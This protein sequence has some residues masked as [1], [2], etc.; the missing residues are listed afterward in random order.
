L[1][2]LQMGQL[3]KTNKQICFLFLA[4]V[5]LY[6][7]ALWGPVVSIDDAGIMKFYSDSHLTLLDVLR[8]GQGYYYRPLIALSYF[9]DYRVLGQN[10]VLMHLE[11]ILIHAANAVLLF[12]LASRLLPGAAAGLPLI[13]A[14]VFAAHPANCEAVSWIAGRTDPLSCLFVLLSALSLFKGLETGKVRHTV[15]SVLLLLAGVLA[16]ETALVFIPVSLLLV[17]G[18]RYIHPDAVKLQGKVL[19]LFYLGICLLFA[20]L[21]FSRMGSHNSVAKLLTGNKS[22]AV[23]S[24]LLCLKVFGFYLKKMFVPWPLNFTILAIADWYLIPAAAGLLFLWFAPKRNVY[25]ICVASGFLFLLPALVVALF[26][27]AWTVAAERYL[28][29]PSAFLAVGVIGYCHLVAQRMRLQHLEVPVLSLCIAVAAVSTL[30]RTGI[31][32]SNLAL[33]QGTVAQNPGFGMLRNELAVALVKEGR[34][35]EAEKELDV[36]SSL[37]ISAMVKGMIRRNRLLISIIK[38]ATP[39]ERRGLINRYGWNMVKDD[40]E[41]LTLLRRNDYLIFPTLG[42][43]AQKEALVSELIEASERLFSRTGEPLLLYNNGQLLL[44]RGDR[45]NALNCFDRCAKAAPDG[46]YYKAAAQKLTA[47]LSGEL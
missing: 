14:L 30:H 43:G 13:A 24:L 16:K 12:S 5:A 46:A 45:R 42:D 44:G 35:V 20:V 9:F 21:L 47:T 31:W 25:F 22:D 7:R 6:C 38:A 4:V 11:N 8:P 18:W 27:V 1:T 23:G 28:Y 17:T 15:F 37:D 10:T 40:A 41:L 2:F 19:C 3:S 29:I 32:Q 33:F 26:D 39:D 36:A 34:V